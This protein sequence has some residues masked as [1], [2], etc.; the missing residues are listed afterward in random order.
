[1]MGTKMAKQLRDAVAKVNPNEVRALAEQPVTVELF[2]SGE[3]GYR[4][5]SKF[6]APPS[7]T[8]A[9]RDELKEILHRAG[10]APVEPTIQIYEQGLVKP[11]GAYTF[12]AGDARRTAVEIIEDRPELSLPLARR[13]HPFRE[14]VVTDIIRSVAKENALFTL[15]TAVPYIVPFISLPWAIG[16]FASDT[17]FLTMNQIRM[18]FQIAAASDRAVGYREQKAE[19]ASIVAGAFGW[20]SLARELVGKI[21]MGGG[22]IP[23]A[24]ISFAGTY[25]VGASLERYYRMGAGFTR[26][27]RKSAYEEAFE[28]G[29][30]VAAS[31]LKSYKAQQ[32]G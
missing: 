17:V 3:E 21:P 27:E 10:N 23:K 20:R 14:P 7:M 28:R 32:V 24:A 29:K 9:K 4:Q 22:L 31:L 16:E 13:L 2:A 1:M 30:T 8:S 25:V 6:F 19:V 15:A 5:M 11:S 26:K 12:Y 18:A